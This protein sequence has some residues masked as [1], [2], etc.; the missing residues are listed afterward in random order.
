[1]NEERWNFGYEPAA[2]PVLDDGSACRDLVLATEVDVDPALVVE[3]S[4]S[5][6]PDLNVTPLLS[7]YPLFWTRIQSSQPIDRGAL[8]KQLLQANVP[9]RYLASAIHGSQHLAPPLD[10]RNARRRLAHDWRTRPNTKLQEGHGQGRWYLEENGVSVDRSLCGTGVGTRLAVIDN[11]AGEIERLALDAEI[12]LD[13]ASAPRT[14][15]HAALLIAWAVGAFNGPEAAPE[16]SFAPG[17]APNASPRLYCIPKPGME[18]LQLPL[19]IARAVVDGADVIVCATHVEGQ[20]SPM[21]D[22]ALE[23]AYHLG[24]NG[25]G[26]AVV[27]PTGREVSSSAL[28]MH[29][30]LALRLG[31]PASDP[32]VFC[33]GPS[34][35]A[36]G[37]FLWRDRKGRLRPFANRG[38]AV[39]WLAPGDDMAYPL[40][41]GDRLAHAES[42]G[43]SGVAAGVMLLALGS[44][45]ELTLPELESLMNRTVDLVAPETP[46]NAG[47][48]ADPHDFLPTGRDP[49]GHNAKHG[50]GR[51]DAAR[52]C[53][54]AQDPIA[55]AFTLIGEEEAAARVLTL[56]ERDLEV[57]SA[58]SR[59]FALW[60]ARALLDDAALCHAA[61]AIAR[62]CRLVASQ[63]RRQRAHANGSLV[64]QVGVLLRAMKGSH[65]VPARGSLV[66][67]ELND[68]IRRT[69]A[70]SETD[71]S[72]AAFEKALYEFAG[73]LWPAVHS[74]AGAA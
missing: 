16:R 34:G 50:Y 64:R 59:E 28:S 36:G 60:A 20:A 18:V 19:A 29:A 5:M 48:M 47:M 17:V 21:L 66:D 3:L 44:N 74:L 41:P 24:R 65:L 6:V 23:L 10:L 37:W 63:P 53:V 4:G 71:S 31:D 51:L 42:S 13:V 22:D 57:R 62:H 61:S 43:A 11:D 67:Q 55:L 27:M 58:Y 26:T 7:T 33:I 52:A 39:R 56:R 46:P 12:L 25:K 1:M 8:Q 14:S 40:A 45:P 54:G 70:L 72:A 32:R 2:G 38:P 69:Q 15:C 35:R 73:L 68:L 30:S 49:D 9:I